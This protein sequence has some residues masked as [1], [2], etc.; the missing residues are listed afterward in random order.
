MATQMSTSLIEGQ[1]TNH[2]SLFNETNYTY[3]KACIWIYIQTLDYQV[4]RVIIKDPHT[5]TIKIDGKDIPK[6]KE[7][8]DELDMKLIELNR[9]VINVLYCALDA[10]EFNKIFTYIFTKKI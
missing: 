4:W 1:S 6:P 2:P 7:D 5:P 10:N 3:W 8:R 9:K